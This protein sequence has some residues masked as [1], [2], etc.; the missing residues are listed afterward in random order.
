VCGRTAV[1]GKQ[2]NHALPLWQQIALDLVAPP[3]LAILWWLQSRGWAGLVQGGET[4]ET[5]KH[6]QSR[7]F[8]IVLGGIYLIMF[9]ATAYY[10]VLM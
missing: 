1:K 7:G 5:T 2:M 3:I 8:W 9:G 4:S 6:R 10:N